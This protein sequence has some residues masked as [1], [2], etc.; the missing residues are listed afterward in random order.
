MK[1]NGSVKNVMLYIIEFQGVVS[2][3][4]EDNQRMYMPL[5]FDEAV[6]YHTVRRIWEDLKRAQYKEGGIVLFAC[7]GW[8]SSK[9]SIALVLDD[10]S[11]NPSEE[12]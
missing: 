12:D 10:Y 5:I 9:E 1:F 6:G 8:P 2:A 11:W 3:D 4:D 7:N